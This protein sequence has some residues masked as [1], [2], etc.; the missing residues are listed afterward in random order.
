MSLSCMASSSA[1]TAAAAATANRSSVVATASTPGN[2]R[3]TPIAQTQASPCQVA[4]STP[5]ARSEPVSIVPYAIHMVGS[6][7]GVE[8]HGTAAHKTYSAMNPFRE[9]KWDTPEEG[10]SFHFEGNTSSITSMMALKCQVHNH[11]NS[12]VVD[13]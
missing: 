5:P 3:A 4:V 1:N 12:E 13:G 6:L 11:P 2:P 7:T 10:S 9:E 8:K